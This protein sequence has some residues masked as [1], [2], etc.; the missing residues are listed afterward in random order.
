MQVRCRILDVVML[1]SAGT[2]FRSEYGTAVDTLEIS[3]GKLIVF[4]CILGL[5]AVNSQIPFAVFGKAV[6]AD[7]FAFLL[8]QTA[9]ARSVHLTRRTQIVR[10][11]CV[12]WH[13]LMRGA[14]RHGH[15][16]SSIPVVTHPIPVLRSGV[17]ICRGRTP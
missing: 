15:E 10:L 7:V 14:E 13:A 9:V 6:E 4:L 12:L 17:L 3:T 16:C 2:A 8:W 11:Q 5:F 1:V